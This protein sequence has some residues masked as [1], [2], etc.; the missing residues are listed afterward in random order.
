MVNFEFE[1]I[2]AIEIEEITRSAA[3]IMTNNA[4]DRI[5]MGASNHVIDIQG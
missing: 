4:L 1:S 5:D 3:A 2:N